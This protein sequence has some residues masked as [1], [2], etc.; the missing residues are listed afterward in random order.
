MVNN[1]FVIS[2]IVLMFHKGIQ[3]AGVI[4]VTVDDLEWSSGMH[5]YG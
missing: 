5:V 4:F 2:A 3:F 1:E